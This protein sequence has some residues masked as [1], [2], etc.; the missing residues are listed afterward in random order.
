V[1]DVVIAGATDEEGEQLGLDSDYA[2][3]LLE[4]FAQA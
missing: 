1:G 4:L 2:D 3:R